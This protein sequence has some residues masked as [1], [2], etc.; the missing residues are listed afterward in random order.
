M[1]EPDLEANQFRVN[2]E[3]VQDLDGGKVQQI[4]TSG[5]SEVRDSKAP[6]TVGTSTVLT[7][8]SRVVQDFEDIERRQVGPNHGAEVG[9]LDVG[10]GNELAP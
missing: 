4:E 6:Y 10:A 8:E 2:G 5:S 9:V 1:S 7:H 3:H